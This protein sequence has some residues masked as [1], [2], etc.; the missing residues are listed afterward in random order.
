MTAL[1]MRTASWNR[2]FRYDHHRKVSQPRPGLGLPP[3]VTPNDGRPKNRL[4]NHDDD[5][6]DENL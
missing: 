4:H 5:D 3:A 2:I 6:D 1:C